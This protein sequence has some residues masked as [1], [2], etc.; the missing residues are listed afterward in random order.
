MAKLMCD[1][2]RGL[3]SFLETDASIRSRLYTSYGCSNSHSLCSFHLCY[4]LKRKLS[5]IGPTNKNK[6]MNQEKSNN[7]LHDNGAVAMQLTTIGLV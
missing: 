4:K 3:P 7:E 5:Y 1:N 2:R 6:L